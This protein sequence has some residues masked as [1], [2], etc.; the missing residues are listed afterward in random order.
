MWKDDGSYREFK[1]GT[2]GLHYCDYS[3]SHEHLLTNHHVMLNEGEDQNMVPTVSNNLAKFTQRQVKSAE[4]ARR[5]QDTACLT[6]RALLQMVDS[7]CLRNCSITRESIRN[8][9]L[10]WGP[11]TANL[12]GKTTRTRPDDI[13]VE[14]TMI[15]TLPPYILDN[16]KHIALCV[17][18]MKVNKV[19]MLA[20]S[21]R[22]IKFATATELLNM[23]V[24]TYLDAIKNILAIYHAR[25]FA[26]KMIAVDNGFA[27]L[28][29]D[30]DFILLG[31]PLN[32]TSEDEHE[33]HIERFISTLK[34]SARTL[35]A[36][37]PFKR[38]PKRVTVELVYC[39]IYW[40]KG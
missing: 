31:V 13:N 2:K 17:D 7:G 11:S 25:G 21:S 34:E 4:I 33:P 16:H 8:S 20:S 35:F 5:F 29:D 10:I 24:A 6:T 9:V 19:S 3:M 28:A 38:L 39:A 26:V 14:A 23:K 1:P 18:V 12:K 32:V 15:T 27:P 37:L 40:Y 36:S 22:L 30:E